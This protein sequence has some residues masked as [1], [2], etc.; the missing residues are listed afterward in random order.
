MPKTL[1]CAVTSGVSSDAL[2]I[3]NG[4]GINSVISKVVKEVECLKESACDPCNS[5]GDTAAVSTGVTT[6][7]SNDIGNISS[8]GNRTKTL[9]T[10]IEVKVVPTGSNISVEYNASAVV[11]SLGC[12]RVQT[13]VN[14]NSGSNRLSTSTS[15]VG[16][17]K[18]SPDK[19]P[20]TLNINISCYKDGITQEINLQKTLVASASTNNEYPKST[21]LSQTALSSQP[22]VNEYLDECVTDVKNR[23]AALE[24]VN[25]N[26]TTGLTSIVS[27][28]EA[29]IDT[30]KE[31][32]DN[33][34]V[35]CGETSLCDLKSLIE[36]QAEQIQIMAQEIVRLDTQY[37]TLSNRIG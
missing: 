23:V 34:E 22:E 9:T 2:D 33:Q 11:A 8:T 25:L 15:T 36:A 18:A 29:R 32:L 10:P 12:D 30:L 20:V 24:G 26:G 27:S 31:E 7:G 6:A 14:L 37:R 17:F 16:A 35:K 1:N 5:C 3:A 21:D 4:E 13:R 28:L 19:F